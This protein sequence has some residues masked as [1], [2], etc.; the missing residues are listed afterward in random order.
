MSGFRDPLLLLVLGAAWTAVFWRFAAAQRRTVAWIDAHAAP[1]F[2]GGLTRY[3]RRNLVPHLV[4]L[5]L[6][7]LG[8]VAA[9]A[10]PVAPGEATVTAAEGRVV[11][12]LDAS[13]SMAAQDPTVAPT[14]GGADHRFAR[15]KTIALELVEEL[16]G[17][18]FALATFSG[19]AAY[20]LPMTA[21]RALVADAVRW[22]ELHTVYRSSGSDFTAALDAALHLA[23]AGGPGAQVVLISDGEAP[24]PEDARFDEPLAALADGRVPVHTVA[25]GSVE[26]EGRVI[27]DFRDVVAGLE[28]RRELGQF[29]TRRVERHLRRMARRSGGSF[30]LDAPGVTTVL[31]AELRRRQE[32]GE[33][34]RGT[35]ADVRAQRDLAPAWLAL[36]LA[37]FV[38]EALLFD[39]RR[40]PRAAGFDL[41]RLGPAGAEPAAR[42]LRAPSRRGRLLAAAVLL[43]LFGAGCADSPLQRA[44]HEN[45]RGIVLDAFGRHDAAAVHYRRSIGHGVRAEVPTHNL[46]RSRTLA[47]AWSEAHDLYQQAL[48]LDPGLEEALYDDGVA[49]W[50]WGVAERDPR[51]CQLE[52]TRELWQ[53]AHGRFAAT[54]LADGTLAKRAAANERHVA[55]ALA[56]IERLIAEPP[57]ECAAPPP[58]EGEEQEEQAGGDEGDGGGG[59]AGGDEA[60][61]G[62]GGGA[63]PSEED[64][65]QALQRIGEQ[66]EAEGRYLRR[67]GAE[68]FPRAAWED[69]DPE[70]WW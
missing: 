2:R 36:F 49:L 9:A 34:G 52:R 15:A 10:G 60:A 14:A 28:E 41:D 57:P 56:E 62:G 4:L 6:L 31:A 1:R 66:R 68:Q 3:S 12:L 8:L 69:P 24:R 20:E 40:P 43:G 54:R 25:V 5:F 23:A 67:T 47:G 37:V 11:L 55:A 18:R 35:V 61:G 65:R 44:H 26:G 58:P 42:R 21:E 17:W 48:E 59:G 45:E 29:T 38:V 16:A 53:A 63:P 64:V 27:W 33:A 19:V 46:A 7:G 50:G 32:S 70:L 30:A 13:A 51:G 22:S 39:R